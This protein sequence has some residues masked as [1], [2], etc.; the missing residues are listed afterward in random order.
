MNYERPSWTDLVQTH[1]KLLHTKENEQNLFESLTRNIKHPSHAFSKTCL[2]PFLFINM[3][4]K[5]S[6]I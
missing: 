3:Q 4:I 1:Y 5:V 6:W 2:K